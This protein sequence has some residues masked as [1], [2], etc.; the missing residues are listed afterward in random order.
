MSYSKLP[1]SQRIAVETL[2][3]VLK[4]NENLLIDADQTVYNL[5]IKL[6]RK[7]IEN[8]RSLK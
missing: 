5:A 3:E 4:D 7:S 8:R 2:I 6:K 1:A